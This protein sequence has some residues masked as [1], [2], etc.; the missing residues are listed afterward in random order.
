MA[1]NDLIGPAVVAAIVSG[2]VTTIG[3]I[4]SNKTATKLHSEKLKFDER[5]AEKKFQFD[6]DLAERKFEYEK[7]LHD[8]KR[9]IEFGEELLAAFY[10]ANDVLIAVRSPAA[11][12]KEGSSRPQEED[13]PNIARKKDTYFVPLERLN[14]NGDFLSDFFSKRYRARAIFR[15][16]QLDQAFQ[17]LHEAIVAI[18]VSASMLMNTVSSPGQRDFSFWEK[19]EADIWAGFDEDPVGAKI[20]QAIELAD[21]TL[22][23]VLEAAA[24]PSVEAHD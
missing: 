2:I 24:Q 15:D 16:T 1:S 17:L 22:G 10:R 8:H 19:R 12:G 14:K 6:I 13:D 11:F 23:A 5:L 21:S 4:V 9:R 18:Q 3:F 20:K 7:G